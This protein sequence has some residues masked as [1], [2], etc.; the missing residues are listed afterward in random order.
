[1]LNFVLGRACSGKSHYIVNKAAEDSLNM[2]TVIIV[3]EQFTFE[4]ER[5]VL[6]TD[7]YNNDNIEVLSFTK[8]YSVVSRISGFGQLPLMSDSERL[9]LTDIALKNSAEQL[10]IFDRFINFSDFSVK[11][12]DII[13]DFKFAAVTSEKIMTA[14]E[15]I[16]GSCGAKLHDIAVI[17]SVYDAMISEQYIDASDYLTRLYNL[18]CDFEFFKDKSVYFDSFTGFTGQQMKIIEKILEQADK[19]TFS[20]CTD[21]I[22][23]TDINVFYNI[24]KTAQQIKRLAESRN[25]KFHET[26]LLKDNYYSNDTLKNLEESFFDT[27][28]ADASDVSDALRIIKCDDPRQET[29]AAISIVKNLVNN[30]GYRYRDFIVVA[31]NADEYKEHIELFSKKCGVQCFLDKKVNLSDTLLYIYIQNLLK[32][33]LSFSTENILS[34]LKCGLNNYSADDIFALEEYI[35][36]W[37]MPGSSWS[38]EWKMNPSGFETNELSRDESELLGRI[39]ALRQ[40]VFGKLSA[41]CKDFDGNAKDKSKAIYSFLSK[42]KVDKALAEICQDTENDDSYTASVLRQAWDSVMVILNSLSKILKENTNDKDY[43]DAFRV[44]CNAVSISNVPQMLDE[45]T[46]GSAD[47]IRPSKPKIALILGANQGIFP[48]NSVKSGILASS[49]KQKLEEVGISLNDNE[50]KSAV[51]ENYLVYSMVCCPVDKTFILYSE[52][53]VTGSALEPSAFISSI[54]NKISSAKISKYDPLCEELFYPVSSESAVYL[55]SD[56]Y[57]DSFETVKASVGEY[58][59]LKHKIDSFT[60]EDFADDFRVSAENSRNLFGENIY[61]S[62]SKFDNFHSCRL[63]Y[64]F[65]YGLKTGKLRPADLNA[66]QRGTIVHFVLET[67]INKYKKSFGDLTQ[68]EISIS[69]DEA[70]EEYLSMVSGLDAVLTPRFQFL[71]SKIS[72]SVK[73]IAYHMAEEFKQS[74][75][76]PA[77]CELEIGQDGDIPEVRFPIENGEM[78]LTGKIDRVDTYRNVIRIVD[79][80]TGSKQ[81]DFSDTLFGLNMQM[82][83]YLYAIIRNSKPIVDN[84]RAGGILYLP[85][86]HKA[87]ETSLAMNGL[88][89]DDGEIVTAMERE[90]TG[91]FIPEYNGKNQSF[92]DDETFSLIFDKIEKL[93]ADMGSDIRCGDFYPEPVD[94]L[95]SDACKYCDFATVCRSS[96]KEHMKVTKLKNN[97]IKEALQGGEEGGV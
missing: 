3:P 62:A 2:N 9:L 75:F 53:T 89:V 23:N 92:I 81:F 19:V 63:Q 95:H 26:V 28:E 16:G 79:Y 49:D 71:V 35:Y 54:C 59:E 8:L 1:M 76:E 7:A 84:A 15:T 82:L 34:F 22:T 96:D 45:V 68:R 24:N 80:K 40:N 88:I 66:A 85:A 97:Q 86:G 91:R 64:F 27:V 25:V 73:E 6:H 94:G 14:S 29:L 18:L 67:L 70:I 41:F 90:N 50:I 44:A 74:E 47:K 93:V 36:I 30:H 4:T 32:V 39:N 87:V 31:R 72:K 17:M 55:M 65:R 57:G 37:N 56:L 20:F 13:R 83:I 5:A 46:F 43:I 38:S 52:K 33:K 78:V 11:I 51:E 69:V 21:D 77:Y 58:P 61:L 60:K 12:A 10:R 42:E 48:N